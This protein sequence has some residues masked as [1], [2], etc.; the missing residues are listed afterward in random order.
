MLKCNFSRPSPAKKRQTTDS[1]ILRKD[2]KIES[3]QRPSEAMIR[4]SGHNHEQ[5]PDSQSPGV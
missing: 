1:G 4:Q 2:D 5:S 3:S